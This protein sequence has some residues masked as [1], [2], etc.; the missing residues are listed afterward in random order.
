MAHQSAATEALVLAVLDASPE[1]VR[2]ALEAGGDPNAVVTVQSLPAALRAQVHM[3]LLNPAVKTKTVFHALMGRSW[4]DGTDDAKN[5]QRLA[6][7]RLL[8]QFGGLLSAET[9]SDFLWQACARSLSPA[10]VQWLLEEGGADAN[11]EGDG[12]SALHVAERADVA[13]VLL[14]AG[15]AVNARS[16]GGRTPL[17]LLAGS[18]TEN[19]AVGLFTAHVEAGADVNARDRFGATALHYA[20]RPNKQIRVDLLQELLALGADP[21]LRDDEG[22]TPLDGLWDVWGALQHSSPDAIRAAISVLVH[23]MAWHRRRHLMLA[24]RGRAA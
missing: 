10:F 8:V 20:V 22:D 5:E 13:R 9:A 12:N 6:C 21:T 17:Q 23:A 24:V 16:Y 4:M 3:W 1:R 19:A 11:A 15:A 7:L 14:A 18:S 2:D